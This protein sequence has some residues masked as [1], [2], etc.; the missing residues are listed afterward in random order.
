V[1]SESD[2]IKSTTNLPQNVPQNLT[3]PTK[4][5]KVKSRSKRLR[6]DNYSFI[7]LIIMLIV[8]LVSTVG[9]FIFGQRALEGVNSVPIDGSL[10]KRNL[11]NIKQTAPKPV[12][13]VNQNPGKAKPNENIRG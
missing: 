3:D 2:T 1:N 7:L 9:A 13:P 10:P 12:K 8:A 5:L 4:K 11:K 6:S